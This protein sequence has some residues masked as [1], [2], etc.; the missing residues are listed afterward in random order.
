MRVKRAE[1]EDS[2]KR[3]KRQSEADR[4]KINRNGNDEGDSGWEEEDAVAL[5]S[6]KRGRVSGSGRYINKF[7]SKR[8]R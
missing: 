3:E 8:Y 1:V 2:D 7:V 5:S 6:G 4:S